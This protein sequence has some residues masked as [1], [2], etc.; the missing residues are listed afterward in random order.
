MFNSQQEV[1]GGLVAKFNISCL[2]SIHVITRSSYGNY[3]FQH[4][5]VHL[6]L[7]NFYSL[8]GHLR[9]FLN[10]GNEKTN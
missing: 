6:T 10:L 4:F 9:Q 3:L 8:F 2:I 1:F 7:P 5:K